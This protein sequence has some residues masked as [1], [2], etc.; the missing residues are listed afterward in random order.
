MGETVRQPIWIKVDTHIPKMH[1]TM[2]KEMKIAIHRVWLL[3]HGVQ[4][5]RSNLVQ[6][7]LVLGIPPYRWIRI[8]VHQWLRRVARDE[9]YIPL[10]LI[11]V[12]GNA[13]ISPPWHESIARGGPRGWGLSASSSFL[14]S[15]V[16]I[17][18]SW[19]AVCAFQAGG[20]LH[21][22]QPC[23][24]TLEGRSRI[25]SKKRMNTAQISMQ[26]RRTPFKK[27]YFTLTIVTNKSDI[28]SLLTTSS[29]SMAV[30]CGYG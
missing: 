7:T 11:R 12:E 28:S 26:K 29:G 24:E 25:R 21:E 9:W 4:A 16:A 2:K 13:G 8:P 3:I 5:L 15:S 22:P 18:A 14:I 27:K 17:P 23:E 19:C 30:P 20:G 10:E 6:Q 1:P